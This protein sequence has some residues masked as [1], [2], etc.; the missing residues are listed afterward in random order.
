MDLSQIIVPGCFS[1]LPP[2]KIAI[3][4]KLVHA[5]SQFKFNG[6][7]GTF[8]SR[9]INYFLGFRKNLQIDDEY[10]MCLLFNLTLKGHVN[11]W[12]H[13][14]PSSTIHS[15]HHFTKDFHQAFDWYD[16]R[17]IHKRINQLIMELDESIHGFSN[18]FLHLF[19][20]FPEEDMD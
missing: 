3:L 14:L 10:F 19:Y 1:N 5:L 8:L 2:G 4:A 16:N 15:L 9:H 6:E 20:E 18:I 17:D 7:G 11:N 12:F 13:T